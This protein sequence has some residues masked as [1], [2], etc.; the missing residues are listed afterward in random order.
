MPKPMQVKE[1]A[2]IGKPHRHRG[3][4]KVVLGFWKGLIFFYKSGKNGHFLPNR[5][6]N[7]GRVKSPLKN[8][9]LFP[10]YEKS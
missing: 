1:T 6:Q 4:Q 8:G 5:H 7:A 2:Y 9:D 10:K 3:A